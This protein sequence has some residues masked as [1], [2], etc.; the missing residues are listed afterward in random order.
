MTKFNSLKIYNYIFIIIIIASA[1]VFL[2]NPYVSHDSGYYLATAREMYNGNIYFKDIAIP[3]NPLAILFFSIGYLFKP[4]V[5]F[6]IGLF[7]NLCVII[8]NGYLVKKI[9]SKFHSEHAFNTFLALSYILMCIVYDGNHLMLEPISVC[10]QLL[11]LLAYLTLK[12]DNNLLHAFLTG[13][14]IS[15]SF[16]SKQYGL[17]IL[18]PI[19][20]DL[21]LTKNI[22]RIIKHH[23]FIALGLVIPISLFTVLY[24][25]KYQCHLNTIFSY[26]LGKGVNLDI[27]QGTGIGS[28]I[29]VTSIL[30]S[31][32]LTPFL[33]LI[34]FLFFKHKKQIKSVLFYSLLFI[35]SM[36]VFYF[37][38][39]EHYFQ[40]MFPY[41]ILLF[42][43]LWANK[44]MQLK[45][46]ILNGLCIIGLV[47]IS[48]KIGSTIKHQIRNYAYQAENTEKIASIIPKNSKV[49]LS[50]LSP[51]HYFLNGLKSV[52]LNKIGFSFPGYFY[53]KTII[54]NLDTDDYLIISEPYISDYERYFPMFKTSEIEIKGYKG[55]IETIQILKKL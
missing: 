18:L 32:L 22:K 37:A 4:S 7:I 29:R 44:T 30:N 20:I 40:Y 42:G 21:L 53:P 11:A 43:L 13:L 19:S 48:L 9:L 28:K 23:S 36:S 26:L 38:A 24:S 35:C 6:E 46:W 39:Y 34:P 27:G 10:F 12:K 54:N 5:V 33:L 16:L 14:F 47:M 15:L 49:Y 41:A 52:K 55:R 31:F 8:C 50:G 17:F 2:L 45:S 51:A 25:V 3:Y 1:A